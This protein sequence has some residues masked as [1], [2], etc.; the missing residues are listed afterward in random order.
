MRPPRISLKTVFVI[1]AICAVAMVVV[2][3]VWRVVTLEW[4]DD[5][6]V[7]WGAG[8]MVVDYMENHDG[9][10][11]RGWDDLRSYFEAGGGRVGGW[12]FEKYQEH[13]SIRWDVDVAALLAT[14]KASSRP[15]FRVIAPRKWFAATMGGHEPNEIVYHYLRERR[16]PQ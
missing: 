13:V 15:P 9:Q 11:P 3:I 10:W 5:A 7:L 14:A 16:I 2:P 1:V 12:S 4:V 8:E 6:Y